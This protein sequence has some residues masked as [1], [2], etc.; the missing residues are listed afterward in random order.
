VLPLSLT[1]LLLTAGP[2]PDSDSTWRALRERY[3]GLRTLSGRFAETISSDL[4]GG[5][6]TFTGS[7]SVRLPDDY[8][9]EVE[10][11]TPQLIVGNDSVLWLYFPD[12]LRAVR[13]AHGQAIPLLAFLEPLTD[14][15]S[16]ARLESEGAGPVRLAVVQAD[17]LMATMFDLVFELDE[18]A[19]R[20]RRF[21]FTD[22]W[23]GN[24]EFVLTGQEWNPVLDDRL[25]R[26]TPPP[27]TDVEGSDAGQ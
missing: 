23:D 6:Q 1:L 8:R 3:L 18:N 2:A 13:Q 27:G 9:L 19:A 10:S 5:E 15:A 11:P 14:P 4:E 7:F 12:E 26:F 20:I 25:F 22:A 24:Y 21:S 17:T 16:T